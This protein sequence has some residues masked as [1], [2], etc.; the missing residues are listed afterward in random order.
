M[1]EDTTGNCI[2]EDTT[3][4]CIIDN[5][6]TTKLVGETENFSRT[7]L[8]E[9]NYDNLLDKKV[10]EIEFM[11]TECDLACVELRDEILREYEKIKPVLSLIS[12]MK[13][14]RTK[15]KEKRELLQNF[16]TIADLPVEEDTKNNTIRNSSRNQCVGYIRRKKT[17]RSKS[18]G[19]KRRITLPSTE[20]I[21]TTS[22]TQKITRKK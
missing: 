5:T 11:L 16:L 14:T 21:H 4:N 13:Q 12:L 9:T 2:V 17:T 1:E 6:Y 19:I 20:L 18:S 7:V 3:G 22:K 8:A 15:I 10:D